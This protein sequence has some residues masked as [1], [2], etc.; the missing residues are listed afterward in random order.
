M[1]S[2]DGL[3]LFI[4]TNRLPCGSPG[5][6][7]PPEVGPATQPT[8]RAFIHTVAP[9]N[10]T[11][12]VTISVPTHVDGD[13][14]VWIIG[15]SNSAGVMSAAPPAGWTAPPGG[16]GFGIRVFTRIA[17]SEPSSYTISNQFLYPTTIMYAVQNAHANTTPDGMAFT[18]NVG[19]AS[20][21]SLNTPALS[22]LSSSI[23]LLLGAYFWGGTFALA[24]AT[25]TGSLIHDADETGYPGQDVGMWAGHM[26]LSATSVAAQGATYPIAINFTSVAIAI[27]PG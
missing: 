17:S 18:N 24:S 23:D 3:G 6:T 10:T 2:G 7:L 15:D 25:E 26:A 16:I 21:T 19:S 22:G 12:S 13:L 11:T 9:N 4:P 5:Y 20:S 14:L 8:V 27:A 1:A